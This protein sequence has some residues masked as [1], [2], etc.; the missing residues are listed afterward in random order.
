MKKSIDIVVG[1]QFGDEGKGQIC[2]HLVKNGI[3][4]AE[5]YG[6]AVRV[7]GSNAEHRFVTPNDEQHTGRVLP[8]AGWV[9]KDIKMVLG[10]G[11]MIKLESFF[12]EI[13]ELEKMYGDQR[14]RV[15]IDPQAG[16]IAPHHARLGSYAATKR[17]STHQGTGQAAANKVMRDG[18]FMLAKEYE[19]L[20]DY[21][22]YVGTVEI[23]ETWMRNGELGLL[24]GSQGVLLALN[25][26]YYPFCTS[27][28]VTPAGLLAEAGISTG[29][30]RNTWAVYRTVPMRVPGSSGPS[31][32]KELSWEE[33]EL[34]TG[35]KIPEKAKVQTDSGDRER[36]FLWSWKEFTKSLVLTGPTHM[37]LTFID[38]WPSGLYDV[39]GTTLKGHIEQM[40]AAAGCSVCITRDG[41]AWKNFAWR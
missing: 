24:E 37:A 38:W 33:L 13:K 4:L 25:H 39:D 15:F 3:D 22:C 10:A 34:A 41:P 32:G 28:D 40:E 36:V 18:T 12:S 19:E 30:V 1:G 17:G 21:I 14:K 31:D 8:V 16:V 11:H 2:V 6:F 35:L 27:K 23:M 29:R 26:G 9:D 20:R 5:P 7:G